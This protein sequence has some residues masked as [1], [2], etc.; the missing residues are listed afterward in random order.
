MI[1][2]VDMDAFY[3]SVGERVGKPV[4]MGGTTEGVSVGQIALLQFIVVGQFS[5]RAAVR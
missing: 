2:H 1:L 5:I 4:I 3:A